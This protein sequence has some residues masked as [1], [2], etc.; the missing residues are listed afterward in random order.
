MEGRVAPFL[1]RSLPG[2]TSLCHVLRSR[3]EQQS[4]VL[5]YRF[6]SRTR[7]EPGTLTYG[8]LDQRA[9]SVGGLLQS[10]AADDEPVG[11]IFPAG[12]DFVGAFFGV[13]YAGAIAV[14]LSASGTAGFVD[15]MRS[16][17]AD[18]GVRMVLT[19]SGM[20]ARIRSALDGMQGAEAISILAVDDIPEAWAGKWRHRDVSHDALAVLQYTSGSTASP[21]G[22]R[23]RHANLLSNARQIGAVAGLDE[24]SIGV[25]WLPH[26]HDMG[27]VGGILTP[28][29]VGFPVTLM[30]PTSFLVRP[31]SWLEA[32]SRYR[33]TVSA[34]PNFGYELCAQRGQPDGLGDIDLGSWRTAFTGGEP[35]QPDT[36]RR[37]ASTFE[38]CGFRSSAFFPCYGL[39]EATLMVA[40]GHW[41]PSAGRRLSREGLGKGRVL[42]VHSPE[43]AAVELTSSGKAIE[44]CSVVI[45][46]P[47]RKQTLPSH[48]IGEIW[49]SGDGIGDGY[50]KRPA[51]S[52][53]TFGACLSDSREGP[54][55]RTGDLGFIHHGALFVTGRMK[56]ILVIRGVNHYP[57]DIEQTLENCVAE[58]RRGCGAV[59]SMDHEGEEQLAVVFEVDG[60]A[61]EAATAAIIE[62]IRAAAMLH[63]GV[64]ACAISLVRRNSIP[65]TT[66]GKIQRQRCKAAFAADGLAS[67]RTWRA[68]AMSAAAAAQPSPANDDRFDS[69]Q[70][71]DLVQAT[72]IA[73]IAGLLQRDFQQISPRQSI[74]ALGMDSLLAARLLSRTEDRLCVELDIAEFL[75]A[76]T[77]EETAAR[78]CR[79]MKADRD[80]PANATMAT[81]IEQI[82]D[83]SDEEAATLLRRER[84]LAAAVDDH[85]R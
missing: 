25:S 22:V 8:E 14:P 78:I 55:L 32:I 84:A 38:T 5:A 31:A 69:N 63:H 85:D 36:L 10:M 37:F 76:P 33:A 67:L 24:T 23:I 2:D 53:E 40:G 17:V 72:L 65:K 51:E 29:C 66:S 3:A 57:N 56:D 77:I 26:H 30:S 83:L 74:H 58:L 48:Q 19:V 28:L 62:A 60:T 27:L 18:S 16:A 34:S 82:K 12:L 41:Q 61:D 73:E 9:R 71:I 70:D 20:A 15:R 47:D 50:W 13:H 4:A 59:F 64:H 42:S 54:F 45:V 46:D 44:G 1:T 11:L 35:V 6:L 7:A 81:L 52:Q 68:V 49:V 79:R 80:L 75:D 43:Q 21:R 39:A